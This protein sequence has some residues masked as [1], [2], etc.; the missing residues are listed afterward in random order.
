VSEKNEFIAAEYARNDT[1]GVAI[2]LNPGALDD[3]VTAVIDQQ[4]GL[5]STAGHRQPTSPS[6]NGTQACF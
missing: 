5:W 1:D 6:P 2:A 3:Q 4:L